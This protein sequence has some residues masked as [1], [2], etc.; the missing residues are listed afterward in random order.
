MKNVH[1]RVLSHS[2]EAVRPLIALAWSGTDGDIFPRDVI[3]TW[4]ENPPGIAGLVPGVTRLGH[5]PFRFRL[6]EWDGTRWRVELERGAGFHGFDLAAE[7][8]TTRIT[9]TLDVAAGLFFRAVVV[10]IHDWAVES[11]FDRL[12]A[13]LATGVVPARTARPM[14]LRARAAFRG[15]RAARTLGRRATSSVATERRT[16]SAP[17]EADGTSTDAPG[18]GRAT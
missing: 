17:V 18:A 1:Q 5:G 7:G 16:R 14:G 2:I 8:R 12:E 11:M 6:T 3:P 4:R 9:H 10:P 15:M 13:A